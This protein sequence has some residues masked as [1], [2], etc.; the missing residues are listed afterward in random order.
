LLLHGLLLNIYT[1]EGIE[2]WRRWLR[3]GRLSLLL[4][5]RLVG[6][7][8]K[9]EDVDVGCRGWLCRSACQKVVEI[10]DLVLLLLVVGR[11]VIEIEIET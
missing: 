5:G 3:L 6:N 11:L 4:G 9:L 7:S 1:A 2:L 10:E 8:V